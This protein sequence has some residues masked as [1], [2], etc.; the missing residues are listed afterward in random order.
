MVEK[1]VVEDQD[2]PFETEEKEDST[3]SLGESRVEVEGVNGRQ[4]VTEKI[5][6]INGEISQSVIVNSEVLKEPTNKVLVKGTKVNSSSYNYYSS[7]DI[8][9][10]S[11]GGDWGWP[12]VS[13]YIVTS[14]FKWRWGRLH[15][16]IDISCAFG[17]PIFSVGNGTVVRTWFSC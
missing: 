6:Y 3:M 16:G 9:Y 13:P 7:N 15:A 17:S 8:S 12:T 11:V 1:H 14:E 10:A 2:K 5:K 4:R